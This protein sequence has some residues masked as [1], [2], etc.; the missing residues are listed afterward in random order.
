MIYF[1]LHLICPAVDCGNP[2]TPSNGRHTGTRTTYNSVVTY[3]ATS[4][5]KGTHGRDQTVEPA[6]PMDSRAGVYLDATV[7]FKDINSS[8]HHFC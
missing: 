7:S 3:I 6:S 2:G 1:L 4:V 8:V 5:I